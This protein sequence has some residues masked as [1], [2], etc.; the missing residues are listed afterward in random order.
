VLQ[1]KC[2]PG[3]RGKLWPE[4]D[5]GQKGKGGSPSS[6]AKKEED[7]LP[8]SLIYLG[9]EEKDSTVAE[10]KKRRRERRKKPA[11][12]LSFFEKKDTP[13]RPSDREREGKEVQVFPA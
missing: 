12:F 8:P 10:K 13:C 4:I 2:L 5:M 6:T 11:T 9:R 3:R 7:I 1:E